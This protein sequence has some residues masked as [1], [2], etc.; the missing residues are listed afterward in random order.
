M[1]PSAFAQK[2]LKLS[3][4]IG[5]LSYALDITEGQPAGHCVRCCWIGTHIGRQV[6][7]PEDQLWELYYTL[8]LKDLGCSS[9]AARIC[10]LYLTDDLDFKRDYKLVGDS[11]PQVLGFV[12]KHTGLKAGLAERFRS[13]MTILRDGPEIARDLVATRCQR[14]AEIAALLRFPQG[15]SDGIYS[16]DEHYNGEGKPARL[17]GEDI[18]I[19]SRIALLAQVI[20]VFHTENGR[21]AALAEVRAR[22]GQWFDPRLVDAFAEVAR[23]EAFWSVLS[24]PGIDDAVAALQPAGGSQQPLDDDYLD[25]IATAFG[26]VVDAK[27]PYTSGHSARVALYT[28]M[29]GETLGL[30]QQRRRW[31]KR[32]A[33][34]HDVGKLGVSNSVLDKA[35]ALDRAEWDAVKQHAAFTETILGR[36]DAFRELASIAG[37]HHERLD[38]SG[39]PRGLGADEIRLETRIITTADIFD[40]ITAA[41]PYRGAIPVPQ[42]LDMMSKT[43][44]TALDPQCFDALRRAVERV[45]FPEAA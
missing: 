27:S 3:E 41:R 1:D 13:V 20:D 2:S 39:Y 43:V 34:L 14:G 25:D 30:S 16:L 19:H 11:L 7:L 21:A 28:D 12:L 42:A 31:L 8:L 15:V 40:A 36:I 5:S 38:G 9:N 37:A 22:S 4:L 45:P 35:G 26:Q 23:D 18:P 44:G 6:G 29:I 33:L 24:G 10:A 17:A 32:G